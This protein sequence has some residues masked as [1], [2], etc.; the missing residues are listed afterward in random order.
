MTS[1]SKYHLT[2]EIKPDITLLGNVAHTADDVVFDWTRFEIP[3]GCAIIKSVFMKINGTNASAVS[4]QYD[5]FFATAV[6]GVAPP[7]IGT[8]NS[9]KNIILTTA[10]KPWIMGYQGL[11]QP[12]GEDSANSLVGYNV[13]GTP[14]TDETSTIPVFLQGTPYSETTT[15]YQSIWMAMTASTTPDFGTGVLVS[16]GGSAHPAD[17]L[18]IVVDATDTDDV[19]FVGEEV[20]AFKSDGSEPKAIGKVT[21]VAADLLTVDACPVDLPDNHEIVSKH[22]IVFRFG[23]EY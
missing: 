18:T 15:G 13:V 12:E 19:F 9:A 6:N 16:G 8:N 22:P 21:A 7:S 14:K 23:L 17:D 1:F 2:D 4:H 5:I 11:N 3:S 20:V 10:A